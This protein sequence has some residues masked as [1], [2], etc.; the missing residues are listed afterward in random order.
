M[1][2]VD[3]TRMREL[4]DRGFAEPLATAIESKARY[5][6]IR[7]ADDRYAIPIAQVSAIAA[8]HKLTRLPTSGSRELL[9]LTGIRDAVVPVYDLALLL[10]GAPSGESARWIAVAASGALAF[11]FTALE[12]LA[13]AAADAHKPA[14]GEA[15]VSVVLALP[16][17][18]VPVLDLRAIEDAVAQR[19][20]LL[21]ET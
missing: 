3:V 6:R 2:N 14:S 19:I 16:D 4:F 17:A 11:A 20:G 21:E 5:L 13:E 1:S 7:V 15:T 18:N 10:G 8:L 12:G 9:G